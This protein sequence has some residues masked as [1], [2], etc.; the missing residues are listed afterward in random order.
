VEYDVCVIL[1]SDRRN[2]ANS[3]LGVLLIRNMED[4]AVPSKKEMEVELNSSFTTAR[5]RT[6]EKLGATDDKTEIKV[7]TLTAFSNALFHHYSPVAKS[8]SLR[9]G[10]AYTYLFS[11][12]AS[13]FTTFAVMMWFFSS[14]A[15]VPYSLTLPGIEM[16]YCIGVTVLNDG[17]YRTCLTL[18][19]G[20]DKID[21]CSIPGVD[22]SGSS[23]IC[24]IYSVEYD[25]CSTQDETLF[26]YPSEE[27]TL[28]YTTVVA[29][30]MVC[31]NTKSSF[32]NSLQYSVLSVTG[33]TLCFVF[34][35][36]LSKNGTTSVV[37]LL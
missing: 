31:P 19:V 26:C 12:I 25:R 16:L 28:Y 14:G 11:V 34:L 21:C 29:Q 4:A 15:C 23:P 20:L 13:A 18:G 30:V 35:L 6:D 24:S 8:A 32:I 27:G 9:R 3:N 7:D 2:R 5:I 22:Y 10:Y 1:T 17:A 36:M 33:V 37:S